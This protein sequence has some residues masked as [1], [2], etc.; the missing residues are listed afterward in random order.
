MFPFILV[1]VCL[2]WSGLGL[3]LQGGSQ[4]GG[5]VLGGTIG[6]GREKGRLFETGGLAGRGVRTLLFFALG[7]LPVARRHLCAIECFNSIQEVIMFYFEFSRS[8]DE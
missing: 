6:H 8:K 2:A 3:V 7:F 5:V 4:A 1:D